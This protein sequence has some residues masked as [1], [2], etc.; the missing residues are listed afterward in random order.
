MAI[1]AIRDVFLAA[2]RAGI[3]LLAA[4]E[5]LETLSRRADCHPGRHL[6]DDSVGPVG[7]VAIE[8]YEHQVVYSR[9]Q[10]RRRAEPLRDNR[11]ILPPLGA[12]DRAA[13]GSSRAG[14]RHLD[15]STVPVHRPVRSSVHGWWDHREWTDCAGRD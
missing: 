10:D 12:Q 3:S 2:E 1:C 5:V 14:Q 6:D 8:R 4:I 13:N 11:A 15:Q 9:R 7:T